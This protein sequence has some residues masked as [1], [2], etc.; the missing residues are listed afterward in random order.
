MPGPDKNFR[1]SKSQTRASNKPVSKV[2]RVTKRSDASSVHEQLRS[3]E[4][5]IK[6]DASKET[7]NGSPAYKDIHQG[8]PVKNGQLARA[9]SRDVESENTNRLIHA[10]ATARQPVLIDESS[11]TPEITNEKVVD[12]P[13][14]SLSDQNFYYS[15]N[16]PVGSNIAK[17]SLDSDVDIE[18]YMFTNTGINISDDGYY[19][20]DEEG[21]ISLT[22]LGVL[23]QANDCN[24]GINK[25][26][27][28]IT[29]VDASGSSCSADVILHIVNEQHKPLKKEAATKSVSGSVTGNV[30]STGGKS[31]KLKS[32][33]S[34]ARGN[35]KN[36]FL[37]EFPLLEY[38]RDMNRTRDESM[39]LG[40]EQVT[41]NRF[42]Q[43]IISSELRDR[44]L[45]VAFSIKH[46]VTTEKTRGNFIL[47]RVDGGSLPGWLRVNK[48]EG[49]LSGVVPGGLKKI[50]V[51]VEYSSAN[52]KSVI[53]F[54]TIDL[55]TG[56]I[57]ELQSLDPGNAAG[58]SLF[59]EQLQASAQAKN[60]DTIILINEFNL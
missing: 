45:T 57:K 58:A 3:M 51:R 16:Q 38:S 29:L 24:E 20:I 22:L 1:N 8:K 55:D 52:R 27:H 47:T 17:I 26:Q 28:N 40:L 12:N 25:I 9:K 59:T 11:E 14:A 44:S 53:R 34:D 2:K 48:K 60:K 43:L 4:N 19:Q 37:L 23:S 49:L 31:G 30:L 33:D 35:K 15:E 6:A 18:N 46:V 42:D 56:T 36:Q 41:S 7:H 50:S 21:I 5:R 13:P 32:K 39:I 10:L 54:I